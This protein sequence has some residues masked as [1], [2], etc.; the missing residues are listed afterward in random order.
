[1][2]D[3]LLPGLEAYAGRDLALG[4]WDTDPVLARALVRWAG[5]GV[6]AF[7]VLEPSAGIGNVAVECAR[8]LLA[9]DPAPGLSPL[10]ADARLSCVEL[11]AARADVLRERLMRLE[12]SDPRPLPWDVTGADFLSLSPPD[13]LF[14][15]AIGN[16]PFEGNGEVIHLEH[17]ARFAARVCFVV[18]LESLG[19]SVRVPRW[20]MLRLERLAVLHPRPPFGGAGNGMHEIAFVSASRRWGAS[21]LTCERVSFE[22]LDWRALG[23]P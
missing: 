5:V 17:A 12:Q 20:S 16:P 9:A 8:A 1:M 2:A 4:Q 22:W 15:L 10:S 23:V 3:G 6:S 13:R 7:R 19:S 21:S 14:Q 18:R 11:D